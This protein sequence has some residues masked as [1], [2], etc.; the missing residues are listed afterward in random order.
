MAGIYFHIPYCK[1]AC[2]YCDFHF[3]TNTSSLESMVDAICRELVL[4]KNYLPEA[5]IETIYFGGGTPSL[6]PIPSLQRIFDTIYKHYNVTNEAEITLEANPDDLTPTKI[7]QLKSLPV[8]RLS[9]G[10]QSFH[11]EHLS[12]MN[13][14]HNAGEALNSIR[15]AKQAG[16]KNIS[17]DLIYG[18]P[19]PDHLLWRRD[20]EQLFAL[21]VQHVSCYA[22]TV[23]PQTVFGNWTKKGKFKPAE[24]EFTAQQFEILLEEMQKH[25]F[26]Q[27][28]ISNFCK[29]G[30]ESKHNSSYWKGV[31]YIGI[32]P[33]AHSFNGTSRQF[34]VAHNYQY[35][36]ALERDEL[37][38]TLEELSVEDRANEYMLTTLRTI[39]G[40][41]LGYLKN[42]FNLDLLVS[43][44][45]YL[46]KLQ[47]KGLANISENK[48]K[49]T[50]AG[51][52]LAD[53]I[54]LD[55]FV[56]KEE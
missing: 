5:T 32:G 55:L 37:P 7:R 20:L 19:A 3:S 43:Q 47:Q 22:L 30:F 36:E 12:L 27:Y 54:A 26:I 28:E 34:N 16:F 40:T 51:K 11:G 29:P 45:E 23:E 8:N 24:D 10:T 33:S 18:I 49:L 6:L 46:A 42:Q 21:D 38:F 13:R 9:I 39:W 4:R 31:P 56:L 53:Q 15:A 14:A 48:L 2:H 50:D 1:Q 25:G 52:L 35:L 17:V 44:K 41:D